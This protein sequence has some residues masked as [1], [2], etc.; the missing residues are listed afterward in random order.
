MSK[1]SK[2]RITENRIKSGVKISSIEAF[3]NLVSQSLKDSFSL[4]I[5]EMQRRR[6]L[7]RKKDL[8]FKE[9]D[10]LEILQLR[11]ELYTKEDLLEAIKMLNKH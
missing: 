2:E 11:T 3:E 1:I 4:S 10:E 6:F 9:K 8:T 5:P 7:L